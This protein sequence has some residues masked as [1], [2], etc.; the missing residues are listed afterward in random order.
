MVII[1]EASTVKLP[2]RRRNCK[3]NLSGPGS[4]FRELKKQDLLVGIIVVL[5]VYF[6]AEDSMAGRC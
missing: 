2:R 6:F 4:P 1:R 5:H 3:W